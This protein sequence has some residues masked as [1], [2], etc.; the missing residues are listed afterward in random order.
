MWALIL[1]QENFLPLSLCAVPF[2]SLV[3]LSTQTL[4][5]SFTTFSGRSGS[6][7]SSISTPIARDQFAQAIRAL[8]LSNLHLKAAELHN[9][10]AHLESSN[11]LLKPSAEDGDRVCSDAIEENIEV[12][13]R[14]RERILL[15]KQEVERRGFLW[16]DEGNEPK[17]GI[18]GHIEDDVR[19][20]SEQAEAIPWRDFNRQGGPLSDEELAL[21]LRGRITEG[22]TGDDIADSEGRGVRL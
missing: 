17:S 11:Q 2:F 21:R 20:G 12:I 10:I 3:I 9:S 13:G 4:P 16:E 18:I 14:M 1:N 15:L 8:P 19:K 5:R 7:M 6:K 22:D